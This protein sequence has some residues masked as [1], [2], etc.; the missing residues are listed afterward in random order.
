MKKRISILFNNFQNECRRFLFLNRYYAICLG[1]L[2]GFIFL[3]ALLSYAYT[4]YPS[5]FLGGLYDV[6]SRAFLVIILTSLSALVIGLFIPFLMAAVSAI[7]ITRMSHNQV[8]TPLRAHQDNPISNNLSIVIPSDFERL[9][10]TWITTRNGDLVMITGNR[11]LY[12]MMKERMAKIQ[13]WNQTDLQRLGYIL[14][15]LEAVE[16]NGHSLSYRD[17]ISLLFRKLGRTDTPASPDKS[18][19]KN[20]SSQFVDFKEFKFLSDA[21]KKLFP[22]QKINLQ[23]E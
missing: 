16:T 19:V 23:F 11:T 1:I 9:F 5:T 21:A 12:S 3:E 14:Y 17:W 7:R 22:N 6:M 15:E 18:K 8:E 20:L 13:K 4:H 10:K 2:L